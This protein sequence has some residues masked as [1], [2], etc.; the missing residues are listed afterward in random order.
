[1]SEVKPIYNTRSTEA[2]EALEMMGAGYEHPARFPQGF[3][4][5]NFTQVPN[6]LFLI[7]GDMDECELKVVMY[8]CR[9]TFGYHRDSFKISTR[10]MA[11]AIGMNTASVS[12]GAEAAE[13]RGVIERV[14]DGQ[15]TTE[16]RA[17]VR[18]GVSEIESL[19]YQK[20]NHSVSDSESQV[21][22]NKGKEKKIKEKNFSKSKLPEGSDI[23]WMIAAGMSNEEIVNASKGIDEV[24]Q[25]LQLLEKGLHRNIQRTP[26]WQE[27]AKWI[28]RREEQ[29]LAVW[30]SWYS[31]DSFRAG[32]AWRLTPEQV[33]NSW[34]QAFPTV[35]DR[36]EYQPYKPDP[37]LKNYVPA[38]EGL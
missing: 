28:N 14:I 3:Q 4:S 27:L 22:L 13:A 19:V 17:I 24:E 7:M 35:P 29:P 31:A 20:L 25:T 11:A 10:K 5:P 37:N 2:D 8:V 6:D 18:D 34:P 30:L 23:G 36:P 32:N 12:K 38:P 33:R 21:G 26:S 9:F 16:W 15:N 1:M